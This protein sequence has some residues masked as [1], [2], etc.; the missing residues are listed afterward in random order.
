MRSR[1]ARAVVRVDQRH[2]L[3]EGDLAVAVLAAENAPQLRR[4]DRA[5]VGDVEIVDA[6]A[7]G[8]ARQPQPL[9][10]RRQGPLRLFSH[11]HVDADADASVIGEANVRPRR[12][13]ETAVVGAHANVHP[14]AEGVHEGPHRLPVVGV[15]IAGLHDREAAGVV[16]R[17]AGEPLEL[18]VEQQQVHL[19]VVEGDH[20][21]D[22]VEDR[23]QRL[24]LAPQRLGGK[25]VVGDVAD[26]AQHPDR[27]ALAALALE[28]GA[29]AMRQ[30]PGPAVRVDH[31]VLDLEHPVARR[32]HGRAGGDVH[33]MPIVGVDHPEDDR[34]IGKVRVRVYPEQQVGLVVP[35]GAVGG[36]V[37]VPGALVGGVEGK[38]EH[39]CAAVDPLVLAPRRAQL[40]ELGEQP[41]ADVAPRRLRVVHEQLRELLMVAQQRLHVL[42]GRQLR[43]GQGPVVGGADEGEVG[44][45]ELEVAGPERG[46]QGPPGGSGAERIDEHLARRGEH[47]GLEAALRLRQARLGPR[48]Q[49]RQRGVELRALQPPLAPKEGRDLLDR[50]RLRGWIT[51]RAAAAEEKAGVA[52]DAVADGTE[53]GEMDEQSLLEQRRQRIVEVAG[54]G[55]R[56][57]MLRDLGRRIG[58]AKEVRHDAEPASDVRLERVRAEP[59][60]AHRSSIRL[61]HAHERVQGA[62]QRPP[63]V[64]RSR[65]S[66]PR[67]QR[68]HQQLV[69]YRRATE[70]RI[71]IENLK[72]PRRA[73]GPAKRDD[74][75]T[76]AS[77]ARQ[78]R[79]G[80]KVAVLPQIERQAHR[81]DA[82]LNR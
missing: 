38:P 72:E 21:R 82:S 62:R 71:P 47:V 66:V 67:N 44:D 59:L 76:L 16:G 22:A 54:A 9:L 70:K 32:V 46:A 11:R 61:C 58:T 63:G 56:P 23:L 39:L 81:P 52:D 45:Q 26:R 69:R 79:V 33:R 53:A 14:A 31:P 1:V 78:K 15:G 24:A 28:Q 12:L 13:D 43:V 25:V 7:G 30:P 55:E 37:V 57:Q 34:G 41:G 64:T 77:L 74:G 65:A 36:D 27:A 5:H 8:L 80:G 68:R 40:P 49:P 17:P 6:E 3:F 73:D 75:M 18:A 4:P 10:A 51:G 2:H 50:V 60:V 19:R 20:H 35:D 29:A 42:L 48:L